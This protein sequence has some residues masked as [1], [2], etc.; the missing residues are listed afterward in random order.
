MVK[1]RVSLFRGAIQYNKKGRKIKRA[2][3]M[4]KK[5][6]INFIGYAEIEAEDEDEAYTIARNMVNEIELEIEIEEDKKY[7]GV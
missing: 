7:Q 1:L 3:I 4:S 5:Y 6:K 2:K